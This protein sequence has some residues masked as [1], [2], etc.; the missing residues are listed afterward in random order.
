MED[1]QIIDT[2]SSLVS[3]LNDDDDILNSPI[4]DLNEQDINLVVADLQA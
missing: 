4:K 1:N 3:N 2:D